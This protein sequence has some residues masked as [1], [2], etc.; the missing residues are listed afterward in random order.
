MDHLS[1]CLFSTLWLSLSWWSST[2]FCPTATRLTTDM[3]GVGVSIRRPRAMSPVGQ[4]DAVDLMD[5]LA[6]L[7]EQVLL[8]QAW[9]H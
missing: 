3:T 4:I 9:L 2:L 7:Q 6:L 1:R 5:R 8:E